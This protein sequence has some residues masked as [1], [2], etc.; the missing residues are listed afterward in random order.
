MTV[1]S[2]GITHSYQESSPGCGGGLVTDTSLF[3]ARRPARGHPT[4][5]VRVIAIRP[6]ELPQGVRTKL[7]RFYV[8]VSLLVQA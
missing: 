8:G 4:T 5:A 2:S 7:A 1:P 3:G 6:Q